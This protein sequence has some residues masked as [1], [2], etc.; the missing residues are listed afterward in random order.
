MMLR[1]AAR[2]FTRPFPPLLLAARLTAAAILV[3]RVFFIVHSPRFVFLKT[4]TSGVEQKDKNHSQ[5][6]A[7]RHHS[8]RQ[9][10]YRNAHSEERIHQEEHNYAENRVGDDVQG[11]GDEPNQQVKQEQ[12][13]ENRPDFKIYCHIEVTSVSN[14]QTNV[15]ISAR[16]CRGSIIAS[17]FSESS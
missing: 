3:P 7:Y 17:P 10:R 12:Y 8:D 1:P 16:E 6:P 11:V 4:Q 5:N 15:N 2:C 9:E 13:G 14:H